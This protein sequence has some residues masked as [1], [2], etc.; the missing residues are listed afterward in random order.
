MTA[1]PTTT[2]TGQL[3][4]ENKAFR[5]TT[6][7]GVASAVTVLGGAVVGVLALFDA[8][9]PSAKVVAALAVVAVGLIAIAILVS[10]DIRARATVEVASLQFARQ[11]SASMPPVTQPTS[12]ETQEGDRGTHDWVVLSTGAR[13][14]VTR[15]K[16]IYTVL[17][18]R[19][20]PE[21]EAM[22]FLVAQPNSLPRWHGRDELDESLFAFDAHGFPV[23]G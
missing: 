5:A 10:S 22:R 13:M 14:G 20:D 2:D 16:E 8:T 11:A 4:I 1:P 7:S 9:T 12:G 6:V 3:S 21:T 15:G 17:A 19:I 18:I 23:R